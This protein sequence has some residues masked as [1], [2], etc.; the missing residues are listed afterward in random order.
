MTR[1]RDVPSPSGRRHGSPVRRRFL[2]Q[3]I[4]VLWRGSDEVQLELGSRRIVVSN[5][6]HEH[7]REL[8][9]DS[10]RRAGNSV[11]PGSYSPALR[12]EVAEL[13]RLLDEAGFLLPESW[14]PDPTV[15]PPVPAYLASELGVLRA[16]RPATGP[17][18]MSARRRASVAVRGPSRL[19]API[20]A[21][22]A[23]A[24]IGC[25]RIAGAGEATAGDTCPG[26]I[27]PA[28]ESQRFVAAAIKAVNRSAPDVDAAQSSS[29]AAVDLSILTAPGPVDDSV[30]EDLHATR[31][32]HLVATVEG[33]RAV[34]G[35][36]VIPGV[37]SCLR[38]VDLH[39]TDR[40]PAWPALAVQLS[41]RPR[42]RVH[43]DTALCVA[44][45]GL[46][47]I[48]A[49]GHL[50]G[51]QVVICNGTL[52]WNLPDWRLRRRSWP[53]HPACDCG[54]ATLSG[55]ARQNDRVINR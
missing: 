21:T 25:V 4:S 31:S 22:L 17:A 43:S 52:E 23:S 27:T 40:D 20:A 15:P 37:T 47:A 34:V 9:P 32:T 35:P 50:D 55:R 18:E 53:P 46:A 45:A 11:S 3:S 14:P 49:L 36:L 54:A 48:H 8:L 29:G 41:S 5:V 19:L 30:R 16:S 39:R 33:S 51:G 1:L 28:D 13:E 38:C 6:R 7:L 10:R 42:H 24:G 2:H 26:G 44:T 12:N